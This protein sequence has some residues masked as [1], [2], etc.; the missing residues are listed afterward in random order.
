M[1][2]LQLLQAPPRRCE[3]PA[4]VIYG[5]LFYEDHAGTIPSRVAE[6]KDAHFDLLNALAENANR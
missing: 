6:F 4:N 1:A 2:L 3:L 5:N